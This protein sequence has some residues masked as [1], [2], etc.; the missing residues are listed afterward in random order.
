MRLH[1][2]ERVLRHADRVALGEHAARRADLDDVGAVLH[3]IA[4]GL[5]RFVRAVGDAGPVVGVHERRACSRS[6]RSD[7][8]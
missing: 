5:A 1:L 8:R 4:H 6:R 2:L 3:L 7:R